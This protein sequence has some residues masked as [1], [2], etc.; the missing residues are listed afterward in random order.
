MVKFLAENKDGGLI[1]GLG[2]VDTNIDNLK[3]NIPMVIKMEEIPVPKGAD[4]S[5]SSI[6]IFYGATEDAIRD[7]LSEFITPSTVV[8]DDRPPRDS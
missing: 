2:V 8:V 3:K 4:L 6:I 5:K 1:I 7:A